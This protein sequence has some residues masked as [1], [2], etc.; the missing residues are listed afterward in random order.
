[1]NLEYD[2]DLGAGIILFVEYWK[3]GWVPRFSRGA[4][5]IKI[6]E[7]TEATEEVVASVCPGS[8]ETARDGREGPLERAN[9]EIM[10]IPASGR[11]YGSTAAAQFLL[12]VLFGVAN[13]SSISSALLST[14]FVRIYIYIERK[15]DGT[16]DIEMLR[17]KSRRGENTITSLKTNRS[18]ILSK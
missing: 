7:D 17:M 10:I 6:S 4:K 1:M 14:H 12:F 8:V 13:P 16:I 9:Y 2:F 3:R 18:L 15:R 5:W 11:R